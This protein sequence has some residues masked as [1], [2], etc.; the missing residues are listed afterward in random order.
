MGKFTQGINTAA[1]RTGNTIATPV[2]IGGELL[3]AVGNIPRQWISGS[4]NIAEVTKQTRDALIHNFTNF[5]KVEGKW[6][7]KMLKVPANLVSAAT[8]R[9]AMI[10][11]G[12]V[13]SG[14]NQWVRQPFK[15]LLYTPGKMFKG[16]R[17][18]TRIFSKEKG[19]DFT[20]YDTH[21]TGK[22]TWV[23]KIKEN[24]FGFLGVKGWSAKPTETVKKEEKPKDEKQVKEPVKETKPEEVKKE[25]KPIEAKKVDEGKENL[26]KKSEEVKKISEEKKE[27]KEDK[28]GKK[29][30]KKPEAE[31]PSKSPASK[32]SEKE[33]STDDIKKNDKDPAERKDKEDKEKRFPE[34][35]NLD[36]REKAKYEKEYKEMLKDDMSETWIIERWKKAKK[37][38]TLPEI[39]STVKKENPTYA[40]YLED[41]ILNKV[42]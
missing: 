13:A 16:M 36:R 35:K 22:D 10:A 12:G 24:S 34:R 25:A 8:R 5:S 7:Q 40:G 26:P 42:A 18:A 17:N 31:S 6:Y 4:K 38:E 21:E 30:E 3:N 11:A 39:I 20:T 33:K 29:I 32:P 15:K 37:W 28:K 41:E 23:N 27:N 2:R 14:L 9:P 1:L 19:F